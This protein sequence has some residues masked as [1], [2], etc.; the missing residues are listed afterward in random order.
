MWVFLYFLGL[1]LPG[2]PGHDKS[3]FFWL[4]RQPQTSH[5][6]QLEA[7]I[8]LLCF[9]VCF[10]AKVSKFVW[11][12]VTIFV[13]WTG[14]I[15]SQIKPKLLKH[16]QYF[17]IEIGITVEATRKKLESMVWRRNIKHNLQCTITVNYVLNVDS[18]IN[19]SPCKRSK[20]AKQTCV[21]SKEV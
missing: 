12:V 4:Q 17:V 19:L 21:A 16:L 14:M 20:W 9:I 5:I 10:C 13:K 2:D 8:R 15:L 7:E 11:A 18:I 3:K 1:S 6:S